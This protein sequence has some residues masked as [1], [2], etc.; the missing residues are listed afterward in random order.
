[1]EFSSDH[2]YN[3]SDSKA[4]KYIFQPFCLGLVRTSS[5]VAN[6]K[7][8]WASS[9]RIGK[10]SESDSGGSAQSVHSRATLKLPRS[11]SRRISVSTPAMRRFLSTSKRRPR[12]GWTGWR[13]SDH[14]KGEL[15]SSAVRTD[16]PFRV[17]S[18]HPAG[19]DAGSAEAMGPDVLR[20]QLR[21]PA[22]TVGSSGG[23]TGAA[24][25]RRRPR[26]VRR[27][28]LGEIL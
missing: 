19:G 3:W 14:P 21:V 1:S 18:I 7:S 4:T 8:N 13:I 6:S 9:R 10:P 27:S 25:Y 16:R 28:R 24:V 2:V 17:G 15:G 26:L 12:N 23:G 22:G 11:N 5:R 20:A